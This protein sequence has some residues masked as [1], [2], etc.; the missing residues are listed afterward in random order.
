MQLQ[1]IPNAEIPLQALD[2]TPSE[3]YALIECVSV[4]EDVFGEIS[5]KMHG[6]SLLNFVDNF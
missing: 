1:Q 6:Q 2:P 5:R 3:Q 4:S